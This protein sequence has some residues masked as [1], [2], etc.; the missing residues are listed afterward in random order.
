MYSTPHGSVILVSLETRLVSRETRG[1]KLRVSGT[2]HHFNGGLSFVVFSIV[3]GNVNIF[4]GIKK[5]YVLT[6]SLFSIKNVLNKT[7]FSQTI[8]CLN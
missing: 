6:I 1:G 7:S 3:E 2:V 8:F 4:C 5:R